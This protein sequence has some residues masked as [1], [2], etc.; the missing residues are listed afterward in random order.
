MMKKGIAI[1]IIVSAF[2]LS[3][4]GRT[5]F[6]DVSSEDSIV[7]TTGYQRIISLAPSITEILFALELGD[8]VQG[9]TQYCVYP[10]EAKDKIKIGAHYDTNYEAILNLNPDLI[11]LLPVSTDAQQRFNE[12]NL[13]T[14]IIDHRTLDGILDSITDVAVACQVPNRA[15]AILADLHRRMDVVRAK[16][17]GLDRPRVL[18]SAGRSKGTGRLEEVYAAGRGQWYDDV[19]MMAGG[20]N[21]FV[22]E[23]IPFPSLTGEGLVRLNP[24]VI[25]EMAQEHEAQGI[26]VES[27]IRDWDV[28]PEMSAVK[29]ERI[30]VL[31]GDYTTIPGPRFVNV[32]EDLARV[33]HPEVNWDTL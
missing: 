26:T 7:S 33:L 21:A 12:L 9:V 24:D 11:V 2:A 22:E 27:I 16:T 32:V 10:L 5:S 20:R 17:A 28:L 25:V 31:T 8:R 4:F 15:D 3:Y 6:E 19:I 23:G 30:Y 13:N 14:L 29:N 1:V 18:I